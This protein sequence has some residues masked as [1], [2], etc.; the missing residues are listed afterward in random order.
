[1][2]LAGLALLA[3]C[4]QPAGEKSCTI[5]CPCPDGLTCNNGVC[6]DS[7]GSCGSAMV[8]ITNSSRIPNSAYVPGNGSMPQSSR[9]GSMPDSIASNIRS[10]KSISASLALTA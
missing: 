9:L 4:Y 8:D 6:V 1:M 2:R 7:S 3:G 5:L 10:M